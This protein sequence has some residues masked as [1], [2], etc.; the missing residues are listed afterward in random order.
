MCRIEQTV[1]TG[2]N[3]LLFSVRI[4]FKVSND[5]ISQCYWELSMLLSLTIE[6]K[7]VS[8]SLDF[9]VSNWTRFLCTRK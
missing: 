6:Q 7:P 2:S 8:A 1:S 3:V 9:G 5:L 4:K